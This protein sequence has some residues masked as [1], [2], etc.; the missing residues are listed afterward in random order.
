MRKFIREVPEAK[1]TDEILAPYLNADYEIRFE[2][3]SVTV[4]AII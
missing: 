1:L 3:S 4:W 2:E